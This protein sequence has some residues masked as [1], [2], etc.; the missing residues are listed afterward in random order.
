MAGC[1][2]ANPTQDPND[3]LYNPKM[4][5]KLT[6]QFMLNC[7]VIL[8]YIMVPLSACL[9]LQLRVFGTNIIGEENEIGP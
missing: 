7:A 4:Q 9:C 8:D 1:L 5:K 3:T 6:C 2:L